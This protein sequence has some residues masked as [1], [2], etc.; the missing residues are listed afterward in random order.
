M[1]REVSVMSLELAIA[2]DIFVLMS[3]S[4]NLLFDDPCGR[5]CVE[6][7]T[8]VGGMP[9]T[10]SSRPDTHNHNYSFSSSQFLSSPKREPKLTSSC[11]VLELA[12]S[13]EKA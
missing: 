12:A 9:P 7:K 10:P 3:G 5:I 4:S 6:A 1:S 13:F 8:V 11:K 2:I